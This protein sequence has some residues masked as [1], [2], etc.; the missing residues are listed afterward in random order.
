MDDDIDQII[1]SMLQRLDAM[2]KL[3]FQLEESQA[4]SKE[5]IEELLRGVVTGI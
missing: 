1:A 5:R 2:E 3:L 4:R